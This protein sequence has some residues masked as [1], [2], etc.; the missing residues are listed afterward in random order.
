MCVRAGRWG[1]GGGLIRLRVDTCAGAEEK[2]KDN[3]S[4]E[5]GRGTGGRGRGG[6]EEGREGGTKL[7]THVTRVGRYRVQVLNL[8]TGPEESRCV[9]AMLPC[10][11][12]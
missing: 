5:C 9:T 6:R 2:V 4:W 10:E 8:H 3:T 11:G 12:A 7:A 1:V